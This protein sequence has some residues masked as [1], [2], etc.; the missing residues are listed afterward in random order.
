MT[1][2]ADVAVAL[3]AIE[4]AISVATPGLVAIPSVGPVVGVVAAALGALVGLAGDILAKG[5]SIPA[6]VT[7]LR[8]S[9][10]DFAAVSS[11]LDTEALT[12]VDVPAAVP[13]S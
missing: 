3:K 9:L 2:Q 11:E 1:T 5:G 10:P 4:G 6:A 12:G 7:R 8:S 13:Q